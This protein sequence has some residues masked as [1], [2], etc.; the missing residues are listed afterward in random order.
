MHEKIVP[1]H[2]KQNASIP[3]FP[4]SEVDGFSD[5]ISTFHMER[6]KKRKEKKFRL[7]KFTRSLLFFKCQEQRNF[8][9]LF[10]LKNANQK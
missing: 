6:K 2:F 4:I 5:I 9:F 10:Y 3:F 7:D 1:W 8:K